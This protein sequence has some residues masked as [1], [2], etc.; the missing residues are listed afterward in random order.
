MI[1]GKPLFTPLLA[2]NSTYI[3]FKSNRYLAAALV[4]AGL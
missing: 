2:I 4:I 1:N 3:I